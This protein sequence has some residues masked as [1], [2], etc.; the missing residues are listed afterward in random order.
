MAKPYLWLKA[1]APLLVVCAL[2]SGAGLT[3]A[4]PGYLPTVGPV[5]VRFR[6]ALPGVPAVQ[7]PPLRQPEM[8]AVK[9]EA[10]MTNAPAGS[11]ATPGISTNALPSSTTADGPAAAPALP[12]PPDVIIPFPVPA[13]SRPGAAPEGVVDPEALLTYLLSISTNAPG[14]KVIMPVFIPPAPPGASAFSHAT[15]ESR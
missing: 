13:L 14:A 15:Y 7:W 10:L 4:S 5:P 11:S 1:A 8:P 3:T 9:T 12:P 6:T 2:I